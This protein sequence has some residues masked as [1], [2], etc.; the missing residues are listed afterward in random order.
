M[1]FYVLK[2]SNVQNDSHIC[3]NYVSNP[4]VTDLRT[5]GTTAQYSL[6]RIT[7]FRGV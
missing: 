5:T 7:V 6:I 4:E 2:R 3:S 1:V